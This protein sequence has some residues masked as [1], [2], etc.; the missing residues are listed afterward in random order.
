MAQTT[1]HSQH[2]QQLASKLGQAGRVDEALDQPIDDV[3]SAV[4]AAAASRYIAQRAAAHEVLRNHRVTVLDVTCEQLP[5]ALV[6][7]YLAIKRDGL[8]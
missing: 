5:G 8:L 1:P 4:R 3:R 2:P 7:R 6:E